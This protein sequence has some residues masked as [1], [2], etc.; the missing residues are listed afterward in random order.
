MREEVGGVEVGLETRL[1]ERSGKKSIATLHLQIEREQDILITISIQKHYAAVVIV[2]PRH[3]AQN[4]AILHTSTPLATMPQ[5]HSF[6]PHSTSQAV[7]HRPLHSSYTA[8]K[9]FS[10]DEDVGQP[11]IFLLL[12]VCIYM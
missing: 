10:R 8:P 5:Q 6:N 1:I 3:S 4:Y 9:A 7:S 11:R 12:D 2:I